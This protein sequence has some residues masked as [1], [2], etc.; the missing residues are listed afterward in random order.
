ML[1]AVERE[2]ME[3]FAFRRAVLVAVER[4]EMEALEA[5]NLAA[6]DVFKRTWERQAES[7][8]GQPDP[9]SVA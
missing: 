1:V 9:A 5:T 2:V 3:V 7:A 6:I 8:S 4:E